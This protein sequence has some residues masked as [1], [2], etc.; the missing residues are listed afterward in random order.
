MVKHGT[1]IGTRI[2]PREVNS[3]GMEGGG[4]SRNLYGPGRKW[5]GSTTCI[6]REMRWD[7]ARALTQQLERRAAEGQAFVR[8]ILRKERPG[9]G[10]W[11]GHRLCVGIFRLIDRLSDWTRLPCIHFV[12]TMARL[13]VR[14]CVLTAVTEPREGKGRRL[15]VC[16]YAQTWICALFESVQ[17]GICSITVCGVR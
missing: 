14:V 5:R 16:A 1:R 2:E 6:R 11:G 17:R 10:V 8:L 12:R 13:C 7:G 3:P 4:S 15:C 9:R